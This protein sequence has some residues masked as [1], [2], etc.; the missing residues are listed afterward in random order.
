MAYSK[1]SMEDQVAAAKS[2]AGGRLLMTPLTAGRPDGRWNQWDK[3]GSR[4]AEGEYRGGRFIAGAP[5]ASAA[6]CDK[7]NVP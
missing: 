2:L 4:V 7:L 1:K 6:A 5:V 3:S